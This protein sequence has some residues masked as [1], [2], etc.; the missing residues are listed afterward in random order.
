MARR[1]APSRTLLAAS[2]IGLVML[3]LMLLG[4]AL[5]GLTILGPVLGLPRPML[6]LVG[7][8][9]ARVRADRPGWFVTRS[10]LLAVTLPM[11]R[12]TF[13]VVWLEIRFVR[14]LLLA[15]LLRA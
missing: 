11:A 2:L 3:G 12:T 13:L 10:G 1:A 4:L 9:L 14:G 5:P 15:G 8:R 7:A 6:E